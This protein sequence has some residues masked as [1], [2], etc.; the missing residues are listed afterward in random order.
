MVNPLLKKDD[1]SEPLSSPL[2]MQQNIGLLFSEARKTLYLSLDDIAQRTRIQKSY[3]EAIEKEEFEKIPSPIYLAGFIRL[4]AR[5][6]QLDGDEMVRRLNLRYVPEPI[7]Y[8][9]YVVGI[10]KEPSHLLTYVSFAMAL[11]FGC[12]V[13]FFHSSDVPKERGSLFVVK[14]QECLEMD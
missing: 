12:I 1:F 7:E 11:L 14:S 9:P 10:P 6:V 8:K 2:P 5:H 4:Y 3:L 13:Y